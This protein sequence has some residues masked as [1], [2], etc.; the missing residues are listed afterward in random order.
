MRILVVGSEAQ[1]AIENYYIKYLRKQGFVIDCFNPAHFY[2]VTNLVDR[3]NFRY[4]PAKLFKHVK[5]NLLKEINHFKPDIVWVFKGVEIFPETLHAL[6]KA[7]IYLANYNPDHP[8]IR[9]YASNGGKN[10]EDS[11]RCYDLHFCYSQE[12]VKKINHLF[13]IKTCWLPFGYE[14]SVEEFHG[15]ENEAEIIKACFIGNPDKIR[16]KV[17]NEVACGGIP[18]D[19]FG[20]QWQRHLASN[21]NIK[22]FDQVIGVDYWKTLRKYR[23]QLNIFRPFNAGSHNMRTFEI[24]ASG[25]I[26]LA[27]YSREN[28]IFFTEGKEIFMYNSTKELRNK[29]NGILN[30]DNTDSETIRFNSRKKVEMDGHSYE[31]RAELAGSM[32][33]A[34]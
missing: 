22:I 21:K 20:Y 25:G 29:I 14:F 26:Q 5:G 27:P 18:I 9:P 28:E 24:P 10:I 31:H 3:I 17:I 6:K 33:K 16:S 11:V 32:F 30:L 12:L 4:F 2:S 34:I 23:V 1:G 19:V 15:I 13:N 7:G 8:F